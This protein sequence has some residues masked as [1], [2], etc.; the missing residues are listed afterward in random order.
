[1][2]GQEPRRRQRVQLAPPPA[3]HD[4]LH[5]RDAV[6]RRV[7][8]ERVVG[9]GGRVR[10]ACHGGEGER[11][12]PRG[13][14]LGRAGE[15]DIAT[16]WREAA[17]VLNLDDPRDPPFHHPGALVQA[18][19]RHRV[20]REGVAVAVATAVVFLRQGQRRVVAAVDE[21]VLE[22]GW[23]AGEGTC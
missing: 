18:L 15:D 2:R 9:G 20:A 22:R 21:D 5:E 6:V 13:A 3:G 14:T 4:H 23:A 7:A 11:L 8:E 10:P 17:A 19:P 16:T 1:M 12:E